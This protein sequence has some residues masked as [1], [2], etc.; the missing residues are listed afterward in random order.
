MGSENPFSLMI[1][2]DETKKVCMCSATSIFIIVLFTIS[3]LSTF[4][5]TSIFMKIIALI[6]LVYTLYL[7]MLQTNLLKR[8][9][10]HTNSDQV[11]NQLNMN[12]M[13]SYIFALFIGLLT[14]FVIKSFF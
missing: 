12:I 8:A 1:F 10:Q 13:C 4:F 9:N 5:K 11:K 3:P 6:L 14:I 7:N 2:T